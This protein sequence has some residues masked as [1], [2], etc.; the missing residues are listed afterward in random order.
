VTV[1]AGKLGVVVDAS[2]EGPLVQ[3][4]Y[5]TSA[6][7]GRIHPGDRI[8]SINGIVTKGMPRTALAALMATGTE[9]VRT[10]TILSPEL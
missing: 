9:S 5:P 8:L 1:P 3:E 6:L 2:E 10:F 7:K 4:V